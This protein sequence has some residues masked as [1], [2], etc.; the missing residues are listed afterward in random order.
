MKFFSLLH[1]GEVRIAPQAKIVPA[2]QIETL[3][4]AEEILQKVQADVLVFRKEAAAEAAT[5]CEKAEAKGFAA[6]EEKWAKQIALFEAEL[7]KI[8]KKYEESMGSLALMAAKKIVG[9]EMQTDKN[10]VV[11]I[12]ANSLKSVSDHSM[13]QIYVHKNDMEALEAA[14]PRL[15]AIFER[16]QSLTITERP[17]VEPGGCIIETEAGIINAQLETLWRSLEQALKSFSKG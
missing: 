11:D 6:G 2:A 10:T 12:V 8:R 14:K 13:I 9:R 7:E 5:A 15:K 3:M 1:T 16:L 17:D 4:S